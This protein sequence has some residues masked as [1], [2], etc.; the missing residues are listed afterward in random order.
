M[1]ASAESASVND[2]L[3]DASRKLRDLDVGAL[4]ICGEDKPLAEVITDRAIVVKCIADGSD[5]S[6]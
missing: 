4:P 5:P 2:S 3:V 6:R 1:T